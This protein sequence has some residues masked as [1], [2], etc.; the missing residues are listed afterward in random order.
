MRHKLSRLTVYVLLLV[1]GI[2]LR[3]IDLWRPVDGSVREAWR[4]R[5]WRYSRRWRAFLLMLLG[6]LLLATGITLLFV[7]IGPAFLKLLVVGLFASVAVRVLW[8]FAVR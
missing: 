6:A 4:R 8:E 1:A 5:S 2:G 7:L 3:A